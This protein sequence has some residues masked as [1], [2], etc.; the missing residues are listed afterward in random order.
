MPSD[1]TMRWTVEVRCEMVPARW[2]EFQLHAD[3]LPS[4]RMALERA[5]AF[6][7]DRIPGLGSPH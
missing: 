5:G 7:R 4:A 1:C 2:H 3:L 6:I